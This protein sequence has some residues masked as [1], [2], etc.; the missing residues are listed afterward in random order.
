MVSGHRRAGRG[1]GFLTAL[2]LTLVLAVTGVTAVASTETFVERGFER[3]LGSRGSVTASKPVETK[4]PVAGSED[5]WLSSANATAQATREVSL[6]TWT[7][8]VTLGGTVTLAI[9]G[10][11]RVL[12]VVDISE[13]PA[14]VTR[15]ATSREKNTLVIVSL[16]EAGKPDGPIVRFV[17]EPSADGKPVVARTAASSL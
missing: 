16:R 5:F 14:T 9:A 3:A 12:D 10:E 6:A 17:V 7:K 4:G 13:I 1:S 15:A 2:A 11:E 8:P